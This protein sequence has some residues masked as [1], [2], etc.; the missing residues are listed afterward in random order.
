MPRL[1][2]K[3]LGKEVPYPQIYRLSAFVVEQL[4][5]IL[6]LDVLLDKEGKMAPGPDEERGGLGFQGTKARK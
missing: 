1:T 4:L 5:K 3:A 6:G 2:S